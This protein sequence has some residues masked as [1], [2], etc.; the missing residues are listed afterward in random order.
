MSTIIDTTKNYTS[1]P[2]PIDI[3]TAASYNMQDWQYLGSPFVRDGGEGL[4]FM[5]QSI[6]TRSII[7]ESPASLLLLN[8]FLPKQIILLFGTQVQFKEKHLLLQLVRLV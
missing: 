4:A 2:N 5:D 3:G 1:K 6:M 8:H 7:D